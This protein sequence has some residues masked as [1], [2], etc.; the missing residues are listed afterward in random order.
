MLIRPLYVARTTQ[1]FR[2][3]DNGSAWSALRG[4][5]AVQCR[6]THTNAAIGYRS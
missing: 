5:I 1:A 6:A 3:S 2:K 4:P